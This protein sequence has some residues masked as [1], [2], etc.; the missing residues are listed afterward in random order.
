MFGARAFGRRWRTAAWS[1]APTSRCSSPIGT[2]SMRQHHASALVTIIGAA[3]A[4]MAAHAQPD[5]DELRVLRGARDALIEA[6]DFDA[7]RR[8]AEEIVE[9]SDA[10]GY[11]DYARLGRIQAEL[12]EFDAAEL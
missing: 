7:A 5:V 12:G 8:P 1:P 3:L 10:A 4:A 2:S 9:D 11:E 6:R